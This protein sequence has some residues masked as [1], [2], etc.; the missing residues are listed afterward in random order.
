M[1]CKPDLFPMYS[2]PPMWKSLI[3]CPLV[4]QQCV[5]LTSAIFS[6]KSQIRVVQSLDGSNAQVFID[7]VDRVNHTIFCWKTGLLIL[8]QTSLLLIR[9]WISPTLNHGSG[10]GAY[11]P[12]AR[13]VV[14]RLCFQSHCRSHSAMTD[15]V[16]HSIVVGMQ[17]CGWV[18]TRVSRLQ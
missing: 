14:A 2:D 8:A 16:T 17:M 15:Q 13:Y 11:T 3:S 18:N 12:C 6:N 1:H 10:R 9:F 4:T 5:S 7:K